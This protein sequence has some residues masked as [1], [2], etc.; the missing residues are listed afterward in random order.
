[1]L[2]TFQAVAHHSP[3]ECASKIYL[4]HSPKSYFSL[5]SLEDFEMCKCDND[6]ENENEDE[7]CIGAFGFFSLDTDASKNRLSMLYKFITGP[8]RLTPLGLE[9]NITIK[10]KH[11]CN[12]GCRC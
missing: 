2:K 11:G 8:K 5:C 6:E 1:M 9:K 3:W 12:P 4:S 7:M 10:F